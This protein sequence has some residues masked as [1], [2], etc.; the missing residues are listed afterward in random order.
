MIKLTILMLCGILTILLSV[1]M[2]TSFWISGQST[3]Q[4]LNSTNQS[5]PNLTMSEMSNATSIQSNS[6]S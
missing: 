3:V 4:N 5:S 6:T 2:E 1:N